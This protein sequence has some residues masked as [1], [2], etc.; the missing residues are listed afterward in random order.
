M[1]QQERIRVALQFQKHWQ[2]GQERQLQSVVSITTMIAMYLKRLRHSEDLFNLARSCN[3]HLIEPSLEEQTRFHARSLRITLQDQESGQQSVRRSFSL[4]DFYQDLVQL[5]QE[6]PAVRVNWEESQLIVETENIILADVELGHF[7]LRLN[8]KHWAQDQNLTCL[9]VVA[10]EPN[11]AELNDEISHPHV[12]EG[13]LCVGDALSAL[14]KAFEE[15]RLAEAFLIVRAVLTNYNSKSAYVRLEEWQGIP[16][17]DCGN[18][19]NPEERNYCEGCEHDYC[20]DCISSCSS[21]GDSRCLSCLGECSVCNERCCGTC[22][23]TSTIS[24]Q[25][26]CRSCR[27][28]CPGCQGTVGPGDLHTETGL[29]PDCYVEPDE[30]SEETA[31]ET[32]ETAAS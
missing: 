4:R 31:D 3:L 5:E 17:Y 23:E 28:V 24:D 2:L 18:V 19:T 10:E 9:K 22:S 8:W 20:Q 13:E 15:G 25:A 7:S 30:S 12:R 16:C 6:F 1:T 21:C 32:V 27:E 11:T 29:C 26:I 14:H